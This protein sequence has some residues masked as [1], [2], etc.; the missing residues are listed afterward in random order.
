MSDHMSDQYEKTIKLR[1]P[2]VLGGVTYETLD[3]REPTAKELD[4]A[5]RETSDVSAAI[6]LISI[7]AKVP[8]GAI[9][10]LCQ[11]D[12]KECSDFLAGTGL[13]GATTGATGLPD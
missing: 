3:L 13:D 11:R 8:R 10:N 9:D 7:V 5:S 2:V 6:C 4:K 1:K 12:F